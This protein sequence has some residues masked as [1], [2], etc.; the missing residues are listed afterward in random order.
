VAYIPLSAA[1]AAYIPLSAAA[2]TCKIKVRNV[3]FVC[4][5]YAPHLP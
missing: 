3:L 5:K 4:Y 1:A 2:Q